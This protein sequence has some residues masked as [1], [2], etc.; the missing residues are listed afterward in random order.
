MKKVQYCIAALL[1]MFLILSNIACSGLGGVKTSGLAAVSPLSLLGKQSIGSYKRTITTPQLTV[2]EEF[3]NYNTRNPDPDLT[4]AAK[5]SY[6]TGT[7][8][9]A[10]KDLIQ[11]TANGVGE[12]VG[13]IEP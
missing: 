13:K 4:K 12:I 7:I 11:P 5:S 8:I 1:A 9:N 2:V 6:V 10:G 3:S